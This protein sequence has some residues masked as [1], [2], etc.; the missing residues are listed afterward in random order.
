[1]YQFCQEFSLRKKKLRSHS[2]QR[3]LNRS[4][5][6]RLVLNDG[7][8]SKSRSRRHFPFTLFLGSRLGQNLV[9]KC[10]FKDQYNIGHNNQTGEAQKP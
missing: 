7:V 8:V 1:M 10:V 5:S 2:N 3:V 9:L 6:N 4:H